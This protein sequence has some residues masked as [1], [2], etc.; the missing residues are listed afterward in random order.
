MIREF[1]FDAALWLYPGES[2]WVFVTLPI[3]MAEEIEAVVPPSAG[4]G[5][6]KVNVGI[7]GTEW[8]TSLFPDK[9]SGSFV[10]PVKRAVREAESLEIGDTVYVTLSPA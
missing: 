5:S 6:I 3:E 8:S 9:E 1:D 7:G 4:F 2:P 10:L